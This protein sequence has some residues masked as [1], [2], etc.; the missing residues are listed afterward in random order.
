MP[1][2]DLENFRIL[3][4]W[5]KVLRERKL[6][7]NVFIVL[8]ILLSRQ[9]RRREGMTKCRSISEIVGRVANRIIFQSD[10]S[11]GSFHIPLFMLAALIARIPILLSLSYLRINIS[12]WRFFSLLP[13]Q[14]FAVAVLLLLISLMRRLKTSSSNSLSI[15]TRSSFSVARFIFY[16]Y[17]VSFW[18]ITYRA[19]GINCTLIKEEN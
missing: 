16:F 3:I 6:K 18:G 13:E 2:S 7:K 10:S 1:L 19:E 4:V 15:L 5:W 12:L 9:R 14:N 11:H 8:F 17:F